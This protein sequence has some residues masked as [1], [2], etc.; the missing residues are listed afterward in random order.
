MT[1]KL[2]IKL[3]I[4]AFLLLSTLNQPMRFEN[5]YNFALQSRMFYNTTVTP[6]FIQI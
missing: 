4:V 5:Q 1:L 2:P 6:N 3:E